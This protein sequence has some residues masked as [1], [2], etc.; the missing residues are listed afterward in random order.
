MQLAS[1]LNT[2]IRSCKYFGEGATAKG[3]KKYSSEQIIEAIK[4]D[5]YFL[6]PIFFLFYFFFFAKK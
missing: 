6:I 2:C 3:I 4:S 5:L 1:S